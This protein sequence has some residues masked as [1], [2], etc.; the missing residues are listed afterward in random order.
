MYGL[1]GAVFSAPVETVIAKTL[2]KNKKYEVQPTRFWWQW[3]QIQQEIKKTPKDKHVVYGHSMG[4]NAATWVQA[5][6]KV[7]LT[8]GLDPTIWS[9]VS[10]IRGKAINY[11]STYY[12]NPVGH[13]KMTG[14]YVTNKPIFKEHVQVP[15]DTGILGVIV[16]AI[17][18]L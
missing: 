10:Q 2:R 1:G 14:K 3:Q 8:I 12:L 6:T 17:S 9:P 13:A 15:Y 4:A 16:N 11:Y 5:G 18:K 7:D